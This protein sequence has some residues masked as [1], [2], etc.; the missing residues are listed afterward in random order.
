MMASF[1]FFLGSTVSIH[2]FMIKTDGYP[3]RVAEIFR[4]IESLHGA[5]WGLMQDEKLCFGRQKDFCEFRKNNTWLQLIGDSHLETLNRNLFERL[6][7]K[8]SILDMTSGG[9]WP[10]G[11]I[12]KTTGNGPFDKSPCR[13]EYQRLRLKKA[14]GKKN[15]IIVIGARFPLYLNNRTF[16]NGEGGVEKIDDTEIFYKFES[17]IPGLSPGEAFKKAVMELLENGHRIIFVYPIPEP[18]WDV[19]VKLYSQIPSDGLM[20]QVTLMSNPLTTSYENYLQRTKSSFELLDSIA[21]QSLYRVYPHKLVCD[22]Q[23]PGRCATHDEKTIFYSDDDHP[24][25]TFAAMI[26]NMIVEKILEILKDK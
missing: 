12:I 13:E 6:S 1:I 16:N 11:L 14:M 21:H 5:K 23:V 22:S 20:R 17:V 9:C 24:S 3:A 10:I 18:G 25:S 7:E 4:D 26:N 8:F 2:I 19:P 15:S